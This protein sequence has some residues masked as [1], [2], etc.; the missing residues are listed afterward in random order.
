MSNYK[1][2]IAYDGTDFY[3]W[4]RQ[5]KGKTVQGKIEEVI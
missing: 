1:M 5:K 3:G 4:Q 2:D